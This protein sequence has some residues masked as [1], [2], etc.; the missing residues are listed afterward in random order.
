MR[1]AVASTSRGDNYS[2]WRLTYVLSGQLKQSTAR[3]QKEQVQL[4][5]YKN[6]K[7]TKTSLV[8]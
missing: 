4:D 5:K 8:F 1:I 2:K 6:T 7:T 3:G